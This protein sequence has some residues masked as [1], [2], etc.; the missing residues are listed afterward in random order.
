MLLY[1]SNFLQVYYEQ[2]Y[3][4]CVLHWIKSPNTVELFKEDIKRY[5][6]IV[7]TFK[8]KQALWLQ[9][10]LNIY[11]DNDLILWLEENMNRPII[12]S[13]LEDN[14]YP[15]DDNNN[16]PVALVLGRK[17]FNL[18]QISKLTDGSS[19]RTSVTEKVPRFFCEEK[20]ARAWLDQWKSSQEL[21][22][23]NPRPK[24]KPSPYQG[25]RMLTKR[26]REIVD[27]K[28][29]GKTPREI[30]ETLNISVN[31]VRT[32]WKNIKKKISVRATIDLTLD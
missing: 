4:R 7:I 12:S 27:C 8:S 13:L 6:E 29:H 15:L 19:N 26:E 16:Y 25:I 14:F 31:T 32:H 30:A 2:Q 22:K 10:N 18:L 23:G 20:E 24:V 11:M 21:D 1:S 28:L 9:Q 17:E 5:T 3:E